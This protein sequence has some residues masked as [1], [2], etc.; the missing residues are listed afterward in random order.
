[1][2]FIPLILVL[3]IFNPLVPAA[4]SAATMPRT[5]AEISDYAET[6]TH[7]QVMAFLHELQRQSDH[8]RL[9]T[10]LIS[11]EGR[12]VPLVVAG[13]PLP[14]SPPMAHEDDRP[15]VYIQANIHAGEVA[16]KEALLM[17]MRDLLLGDR[18]ELLKKNVFLFVPNYNSDGNERLSPEN[19]SYMPNPDKGVG[20]RHTSQG[21][22]LNR[23]SI[24]TDA[25]E[26]HAL[27][28]RLILHWDPHVFI[29]LHTTDGS[30]HQHTVTYLSARAPN[31][32]TAISDYLWN[33]L[34]PTVDRELRRRDIKT[35]PYGNFMHRAE[36]EKGWG[37]FA[38]SPRILVDY[39]GLRNRL[40]ILVEMYA[41]APYRTRVEHC[42]ALLEE[43]AAF[44]SLQG[45]TI[46][47]LVRAADL[48]AAANALQPPAEREPVC[49]E[50]SSGPLPEPLTIESFVLEPFVDERGRQ[51]SRPLL[52][53]PKTYEVPYFARFE[54]VRSTPAPWA[55][56]LPA[57]TETAVAQLL[58]HGV[59]VERILTAGEISAEQFF[60]TELK[61]DERLDQGHNALSLKGEWKG[62]TLT[63]KTGDYLVPMNQ[64]LARLTVCL[65]EPEH[66]DSL[67]SWN[68]FNN[69]VTR[70]WYRDLP[71]LPIYKIMEP[72][73]LNTRRLTARD[74]E[75]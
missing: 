67:V 5:Q 47:E 7:E 54:C 33:T 45:G 18:Q 56:V 59:R 9:E 55:Y 74:L 37:T 14:Q 21:Y 38:P 31:W 75:D 3:T 72:L 60:S 42:L 10:L 50:V 24:K 17:F 4:T 35:L 20:V 28:E 48:A 53:Q 36:P 51:R 13:D 69:F 71:P 27:L 62:Q 43:L 73:P 58:R 16:G 46:Q 29:D 64:S 63:L 11:A 44:T 61:V 8:M 34:Y 65:L 52:D 66:P 68:F 41:F 6:T 32:D 30:F 15:I 26:T 22:D 70:Q 12:E 49:L 2:R 40:A 39:M 1:M 19:R 57:G 23:D 25:R